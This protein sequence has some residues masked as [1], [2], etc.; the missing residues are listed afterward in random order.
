MMSESISNILFRALSERGSSESQGDVMMA[1]CFVRQEEY[2]ERREET[3]KRH[4]AMRMQRQEPFL[5]A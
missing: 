1:S 3:E 2:A 4:H 5:L